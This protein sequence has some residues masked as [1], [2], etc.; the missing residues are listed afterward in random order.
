MS[1]SYSK[2]K[3]SNLKIINN[4]IYDKHGEKSRDHIIMI[5]SPTVFIMNIALKFNQITNSGGSTLYI[6][7]VKLNI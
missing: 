5:Y 4:I 2:T 3:L 6:Y 1:Y 7:S